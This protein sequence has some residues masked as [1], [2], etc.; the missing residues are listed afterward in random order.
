MIAEVLTMFGSAGLIGLGLIVIE[1]EANLRGAQQMVATPEPFP[2]YEAGVPVECYPAS[3]ETDIVQA[4]RIAAADV[5]GI[6]PAAVERIRANVM[7]EVGRRR[8]HKAGAR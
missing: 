6:D 7:D 4:L 3:V 2:T 5:N 1:G 8:E